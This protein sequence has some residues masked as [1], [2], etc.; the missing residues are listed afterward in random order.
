MKNSKQKYDF[1]HLMNER[2]SDD[3]FK[4]IFK[5][6]RIKV[7]SLD[8]PP[9]SM[10]ELIALSDEF[11]KLRLTK[12]A[13]VMLKIAEGMGDPTNEQPPLT[14][15][16]YEQAE[17]VENE[18]LERRKNDSSRK[19]YQPTDYEACGT[20]GYDHAYDL[21]SDKTFKDS[22]KKHIDKDDVPDDFADRLK[23]KDKSMSEGK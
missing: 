8:S 20:C 6:E 7:A 5:P 22:V 11:E 15:L 23:L 21:I 19:P 13:S 3:K 1:A 12:F 14:D 2:L 10:M 18:E 9:N 16:D 17:D 4:S